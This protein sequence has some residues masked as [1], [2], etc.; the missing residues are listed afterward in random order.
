MDN[1]KYLDKVVDHMIKHSKK[2]KF[3]FD[4]AK[5]SFTT[6]CVN[7]FG[8][9]DDEIDYVFFHYRTLMGWNSRNPY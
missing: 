7:T 1:K 8:L 6:Y 3:P 4:S 9:T 5:M 2:D